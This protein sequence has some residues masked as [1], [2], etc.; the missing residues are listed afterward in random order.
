[1]PSGEEACN[2]VF[3]GFPNSATEVQSTL[4]STNGNGKTYT[5]DCSEVGRR[6]IISPVKLS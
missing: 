4:E 2:V 6:P 3:K 1:M 5:S